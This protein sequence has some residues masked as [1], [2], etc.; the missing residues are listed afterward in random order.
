MLKGMTY[1]RF[2]PSDWRSGCLALNLEEEGLY[3]RCCAFMYDT[4]QPIP[5]NDTVAA[6][7][8]NVQVQKYEKVMK[9]LVA[10]GKMIRAQGRIINERVDQEIHK[11][12]MAMVA[13]S[14]AAKKREEQKR[15]AQEEAERAWKEIQ[16]LQK[17]Q[18]AN[19]G[20]PPSTPQAT[21]LPT[22]PRSNE[23][24]TPGQ[25]EIVNQINEAKAAACQT[26]AQYQKPEARKKDRSSNEDLVPDGTSS[27]QEALDAF[28]AYNDLAQR[29]GLPLARTLTPQRRKGIQARMRE[30]GG[31]QA[32]Q[33]ALANIERS[34]FLRG[35]NNRRWR[36]DLDFMIQPKSFTRLIEGGYGNGAHAGA[37]NPEETE[38]E[39][40]LRIINEAE[41][42]EGRT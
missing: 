32:W 24:P 22:P 3:I 5:G 17:Q 16:D 26:S 39:R 10:K 42:K 28:H 21:P 27:P 31:P 25:K 35:H 1:A 15:R 37:D 40:W 13:R 23:P 41:Q 7:L 33:D 6:K 18:A 38:Q 12:R 30:H 11:Y 8:L 36:A 9:S 2:F 14:E 4:G 29:A 20:P 34:A 19:D